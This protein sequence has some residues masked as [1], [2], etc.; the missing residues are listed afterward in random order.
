MNIKC[1]KC[2]STLEEPG[3]LVFSPPDDRSMVVKTHVCKRC[4]YKWEGLF[5][6]INELIPPAPKIVLTPL[7]PH[8]NLSVT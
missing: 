7:A 2:K 6:W 4:Y 1:D 3:A 5:D 8:S